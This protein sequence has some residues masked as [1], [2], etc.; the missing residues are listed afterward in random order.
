MKEILK[1]IPFLKI[2][3]VY[4]KT[5]KNKQNFLQKTHLFFNF[6]KDFSLYSKL[7]K[8]IEIKAKTEDLF[9][10]IYDNTADTKIDPIYYLQ[11]TWC[12]EKIFKAKPVE[13][14]DVGSHYLMVGIIS[15]FVPTTMVDIRPLSVN[16]D[17][18]SFIKGDITHLPFE[19]D[20]INSL[21][22]I[23]V[24]EHIGLGRYGDPLDQ[25]GTEKSAKELSRVLSNG[26]SLYISVPVDSKSK[27]YFNAHRAFTRDYILG[28]FKDLN[29]I[30]ERYIYGKQFYNEYNS[31]K[32]FGTG[33][34]Y[35]RK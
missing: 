2:I 10:R 17:S 13:H 15:K 12:A 29:L 28:L 9:P 6:L 16:L 25:F 3:V 19:N 33:L 7:E 24:I 31:T 27:V 8:N 22:S 34:Y 1:K 23:C 20:S 5:I 4:S 35:F 26:G 32:G 18:L 11:S 21:S 30:E 14:Y